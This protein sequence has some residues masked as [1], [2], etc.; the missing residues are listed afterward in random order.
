G[1]LELAGDFTLNS[2]DLITIN[3][4][5]LGSGA[6]STLGKNTDVIIA[7]P[8]K[9]GSSSFVGGVFD[10]QATPTPFGATLTIND[11][12]SPAGLTLTKVDE[13]TV[14]LPN[15]NP[16][17]LAGTTINL[18]TV[19]V[20]NGQALGPASPTG[21]P[22]VVNYGSTNGGTLQLEGNYTINKDLTLN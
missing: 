3:G 2:E 6:L 17:F 22:V 21:G 4:T 11:L 18:G 15:A 10:Y 19:I 8:V 5:G 14:I 7:S 13:N 1:R 12:S 16:K 9:L 20:R